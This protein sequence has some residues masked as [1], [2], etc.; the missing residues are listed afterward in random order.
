MPRDIGTSTG[1]NDSVTPSPPAAARFCR[2]S[3]LWRWLPPTAYG[4]AD[5]WI[6]L[7]SRCGFRL[8]PAPD[9]PTASTGHEV[10]R[11]DHLRL[12]AGR[13][14]QRDG[15]HV[16][17][18]NRD[19]LR[20]DQVPPLPAAVGQ[21]EF[22]Q[23]VRPRTVELAA[24][25]RCPGGFVCESMIGTAV[26]D[27]GVIAEVLREFAGHAVRQR[28]EHDVVPRQVLWCRVDQGQVGE[29]TQVRLHLDE[30][31]AGVGMGCDC[32]NG[33]VGVAREKSQ[34]FATRVAAG[35]SNGNGKRH[36]STLMRIEWT[37]GRSG[38]A[39]VLLTNQRCDVAESR[40]T[41]RT[42]RKRR[43]PASRGLSTG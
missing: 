22:R 18:G 4:A 38:D 2:I 40:R 15:G 11:P 19:A 32:R 12:D 37:F 41:R 17:S 13:E 6:S 14:R 36:V 24:V 43:R 28:D 42:R 23:P 39:A 25:E 9:V 21:H 26:D 5:P 34:Q 10:V 27:E 20:A 29:R 35:T 16:A 3:G 1:V 31:L 30:R 7:A 8:L 33:D